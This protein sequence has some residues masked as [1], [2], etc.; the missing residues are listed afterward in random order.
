[1]CAHCLRLSAR[2]FS[3]L[4]CVAIAGCDGLKVPK[5][6]SDS[7]PPTIRW[8]VRDSGTGDVQKFTGNGVV[9]TKRGKHFV[10]TMKAEDSG[11][12]SEITLGGTTSWLCTMGNLAQQAG[13]S[14]EATEK[15]S[16]QPDG[17]GMVLTEVPIIR[18]V[19]LDFDCQPGYQFKSATRKLMGSGKNYFGGVAQAEL[20]F[21]VSP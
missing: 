3:T 17:D 5:P 7:T 2:L 8:H 1:M 19:E 9:A 6:S 15:Q 21:K 10:V 20:V 16:L 14:L 4:L 12:V 18:N 11:G 13:P